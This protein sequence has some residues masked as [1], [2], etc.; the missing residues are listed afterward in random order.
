VSDQ[1][2]R[3]NTQLH[4]IRN[5]VSPLDFKLESLGHQIEKNRTTFETK[6]IHLESKILEQS[7]LIAHQAEQL[8]Q[9]RLFLKM[10]EIVEIRPPGAVHED[11]QN[12]VGMSPIT[13]PN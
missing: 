5:F 8:R 12:P 10:P 4:E 7:T 3:I 13:P 9:I 6:T 2:D 11:K 1:L